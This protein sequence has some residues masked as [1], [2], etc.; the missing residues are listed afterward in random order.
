MMFAYT[1]E[2]IITQGDIP[3][4][5]PLDYIKSGY[6]QIYLLEEENDFI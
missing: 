3:L 5:N 4:Y 6:S 2:F 1:N